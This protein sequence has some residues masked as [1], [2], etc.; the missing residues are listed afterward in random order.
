[1][2][3]GSSQ[4]VSELARRVLCVAFDGTTGADAPLERLAELAPGA[5][6]V[7][8]RNVVG[9]AQLRALIADLREAAGDPAIAIDQE[10]GRVVRVPAETG[11][12]VDLP[13]MMALG[14]TR[15]A[16]LAERAGKRLGG[17]LARLGFNIDF[18]PV[19]DLALEPANTVIGTRAFG[20]DPRLVAELGLAFARGLQ[21]GGVIPVAKHFPGHGATSIDSHFDLP[22]LGVDEATWRTRDVLPF[23][24]AV[25][26]GL[27]AIMTAHVVVPAFD[28]DRPATLSPAIVDRIL[29]SELGFDGVVFSD[30]LEMGAIAKSPGT[31]AA[32]PLALAAGVDA[33]IVSHRIDCAWAAADAIVRAVADGTLPRRRLEE[34]ASRVER[35][36]GNGQ[37]QVE[38]ESDREIGEEIA[39]RALTVLRGSV[40]LAA[41]SAITVVS[42]EGEPRAS[43][44]SALR[45]RGIKS[46][47]MRVELDP[48]DEDRAL[49]EMVLRGLSGRQIAIVARR[50]HL[51]PAQATAIARI[52]ELAPDAILI[53]AQEPYDAAL[54]PQAGRLACTYDDREVTIEALAGAMTGNAVPAGTLPVRLDPAA[55]R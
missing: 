30:C 31:A 25:E 17:D 51:H 11:E 52:L 46:E 26:G 7:F 33:L 49:L 34:A 35:L 42:F 6:I 9:G 24:A 3:R 55:A 45:R 37:P 36:R 29:R 16:G 47:H 23:A 1:M 12:M 15:D 4:A 38:M 21:A 27:P 2:A 50:A 5:L 41:E 19:F 44:S 20:E 10:G 13:A 8:A 14:A 28:P 18:A 39:R 54:F 53:S 22:V 40:R 43:L 32:A 48:G